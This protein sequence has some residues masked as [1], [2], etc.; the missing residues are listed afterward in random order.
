VNLIGISDGQHIS[1]PRARNIA[2]GKPRVAH[3]SLAYS[4]FAAMSM[5]ML[6]IGVCGL[7]G[8]EELTE[9]GPAQEF[10]NAGRYVDEL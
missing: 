6:G 7:R 1:D 4:A 5:G 8:Q 9:T 2:G 3:F 10:D